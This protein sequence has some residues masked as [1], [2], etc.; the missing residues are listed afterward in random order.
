MF[1]HP[2]FRA[3][4][5]SLLP[6]NCL[7][8]GNFFLGSGVCSI[9]FSLLRSRLPPLCNKC[10]GRLNSTYQE[11]TC[12]EC[13]LKKPILD[14]FDAAFDYEPVAGIL[15]R[16]AKSRSQSVLLERLLAEESLKSRLQ[17]L[18]QFDKV[19][20]VPDRKRRYIQRGFSPVRMIGSMVSSELKI[21]LD[22]FALSWCRDAPRQTGL[23]KA[24]RSKNLAGAFKAKDV[25][26]LRLLLVD[27]VYTTGRTL[28]EA[29][30]VLR[31]SGAEYVYGFTLCY[32]NGGLMSR[33]SQ[34]S[35]NMPT[36][37][38]S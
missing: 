4:W 2:I 36:F 32:R 37:H 3:I 23:S 7:I 31:R 28:N 8:C 19:V 38:P 6:E 12:L 16:C 5:S 22:K 11:T 15:L 35:R 17:S 26:K 29:A 13:I 10:G 9:C 33:P 20:V 34:G 25:S 18:Q 21:P 30:K 1:D 14:G 24:K 27:D